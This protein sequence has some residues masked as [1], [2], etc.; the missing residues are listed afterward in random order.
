[1]TI[2]LGMRARTSDDEDAGV[3]ERLIVAGGAVQAAVVRRGLIFPRAVPV[4]REAIADGPG[5]EARLAYT[6]EELAGFPAFAPRAAVEDE[7]PPV[8]AAAPPPAAAGAPTGGPVPPMPGPEAT[9]TARAGRRSAP[10]SRGGGQP[11]SAPA[12]WWWARTARWRAR[13]SNWASSRATA[14]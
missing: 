13:S 7:G 5:G 11:R 3:I 10:R 4:P 2:R 14:A 6:V 12:A 8:R 9:S 1:M